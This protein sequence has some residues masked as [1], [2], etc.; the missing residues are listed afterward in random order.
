MGKNRAGSHYLFL[1]KSRDT[2]QSDRQQALRDE[3]EAEF[4]PTPPVKHRE[5]LAAQ[6]AQN[7]S[8]MSLELKQSVPD[9]C[10]AG[11]GT[12]GEIVFYALAAV[13]SPAVD[14]LPQGMNREDYILST[15]RMHRTKNPGFADYRPRP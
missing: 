6:R 15:L 5:K 14:R 10:A 4:S 3:E 8:V 12:C 1:A 11:R 7:A 9:V 2:R 13:E